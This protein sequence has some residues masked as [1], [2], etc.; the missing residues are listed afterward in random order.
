MLGLKFDIYINEKLL[1]SDGELNLFPLK[2]ECLKDKTYPSSLHQLNQE[3]VIGF[4]LPRPYLKKW[5]LQWT[6]KYV[7]FKLGK[8]KLAIITPSNT[9][10]KNIIYVYT[11]RSPLK[12]YDYT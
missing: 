10:S 4:K 5:K 9:A 8:I 6:T 7:K 12:N 3:A 1:G 2:L 11:R